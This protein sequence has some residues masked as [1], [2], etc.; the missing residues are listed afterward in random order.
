MKASWILNTLLVTASL[1]C[2]TGS[3]TVN[4]QQGLHFLSR[5]KEDCTS[6]DYQPDRDKFSIKLKFPKSEN[7]IVQV[8]YTKCSYQW[9]KLFGEYSLNDQIALLEELLTFEN[10]TSLSSK[11]V[12]RYGA[13]DAPAPK[14]QYYNLQTEALYLLTLLTVS[15]YSPD[16]CPYP[17]LVDTATGEEIN[18]DF[19]KMKQVFDI[20]REWLKRNKATNF[21]A[22]EMPLLHSRYAWYGANKSKAYIFAKDFKVK[23][24]GAAGLVIGRCR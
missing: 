2:G 8:H 18:G 7:G 10:D 1:S 15:S 21:T 6:G 23:G 24:L 11:K 17:V 20:Y 22:I 5:E 14:T 4:A 9:D 3:R 12:C 13:T 19:S 16:Y